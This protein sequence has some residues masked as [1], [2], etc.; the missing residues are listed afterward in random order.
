MSRRALPPQARWRVKVLIVN[1]HL[2]EHCGV[3]S[4][5]KRIG[6]ILVNDDPQRYTYAEANAPDEMR[7]L[8]GQAWNAIIYNY[9][10]STMGWLPG[11]IADGAGARPE[12]ATRHLG[13]IHEVTQE[14]VDAEPAAWLDGWIVS[15]P[16]LDLRGRDPR[17]FQTVRP[18]PSPI[19]TAS[20]PRSGDAPRIGS[21]GFAFPNKGFELLTKVVFDELDE[22]ELRLHVTQAYFSGWGPMTT[23]EEIFA[24][25]R[26]YPRKPGQ[27]L[28][29]TQH[30]MS[31]ED[32]VNWLAQNDLNCLFYDPNPGRGI[33]STGD[34]CVSS[35]APLLATR[36]EQFR[37]VNNILPPFPD[38]SPRNAIRACAT[39]EL[40]SAWSHQRYARDYDRILGDGSAG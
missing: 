30:F 15:D 38:C 2:T 23:P 32:L 1:H 34:F 7:G 35:G 18:L 21:F 10:P 37:H 5:G 26:Q 36:S 19:L 25:C 39:T 28:T 20:V 6:Q 17:W 12:I 3:H 14:T 29:C 13:L 8:M 33:A 22:V 24:R 11:W 27:E 4:M 16:S 40:Q 9:H 31:D